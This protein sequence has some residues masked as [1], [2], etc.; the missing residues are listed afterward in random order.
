MADFFAWF[1]TMLLGAF[2]LLGAG[3][4]AWLFFFTGRKVKEG[5]RGAPPRLQEA[6]PALLTPLILG[7]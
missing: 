1:L 3:A 6:L 2:F 5:D 7:P 4:K